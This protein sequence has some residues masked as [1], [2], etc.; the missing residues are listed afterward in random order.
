MKIS[1][2]FR[3]SQVAVPADHALMPHQALNG[4]GHTRLERLFGASD[5]PKSMLRKPPPGSQSHQQRYPDHHRQQYSN[6]LF[7]ACFHQCLA[8]AEQIVG[9]VL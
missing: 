8:E 3:S 9:G 2:S 1:R 7:L 4:A 5:I 6:N